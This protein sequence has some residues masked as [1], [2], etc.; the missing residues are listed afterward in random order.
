MVS[1]VIDVDSLKSQT[2]PAPKIRHCK[3]CGGDFIFSRKHRTSTSTVYCAE[4]VPKH[5]QCKDIAFE[6][7]RSDKA[8]KMRLLKEHGASCWSCENSMWMGKPIPLELEHIDG[9]PDNNTRENLKI[10]CSNCHALTPTYKGKNKLRDGNARKV[11]R[12]KYRV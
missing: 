8:R 2:G 9:N 3:D 12:S 4:C 5:P 11:R 6:D 7:L 1:S 10:L